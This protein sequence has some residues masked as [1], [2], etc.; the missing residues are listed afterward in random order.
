MASNKPLL[1]RARGPLLTKGA[2]ESY[3]QSTWSSRVKGIWRRVPSRQKQFCDYKPPYWS[4]LVPNSFIHSFTACLTNVSPKY[5]LFSVSSPG[6]SEEGAQLGI[7]REGPTQDPQRSPVSSHLWKLSAECLL[8]LL[9]DSQRVNL[10]PA[11]QKSRCF[12]SSQSCSK[13]SGRL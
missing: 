11:E 7:T 13:V 1:L 8:L 4:H 5:T 6:L 3:R 12:V 10:H 2:N 9:T